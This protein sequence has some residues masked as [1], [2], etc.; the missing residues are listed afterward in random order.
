MKA[1]QH[2]LRASIIRALLLFHYSFREAARIFGVSK[3][4]VRRLYHRYCTDKTVDPRPRGGGQPPA[5]NDQ[6]LEKLRKTIAE[7]PDA[8]LSELRDLC[9]FTCSI[10]ALWRALTK[11]GWSRKKK[12]VYAC[13][14]NSPKCN[15][16]RLE[17][18]EKI[19]YIPTNRL[20]Y[21]DESGVNT[22]MTRTYAWS[23]VGERAVGLAPRNWTAYSVLS[24]LRLE[25]VVAAMVIEGSTDAAVFEAF[26]EKCLVPN[27]RPGDT[28]IWDNLSVHKSVRVKSLIENAGATLLPLPTYSPRLNPIER[29]WSKFKEFFRS[30][31]ARVAKDIYR[32]AREALDKVTSNDILGWFAD[33]MSYLPF[34]Q[35]SLA[36][37]EGKAP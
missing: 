14:A 8:T 2:D 6:Q 32:T 16:E 23:P 36:T 30:S 26:I 37:N 35:G 24:A 33:S 20:V 1:Y 22:A 5:L 4:F 9:G 7:H 10:S 28:V 18:A 3:D 15:A 31:A 13:E 11:M 29:M 12:V 19:A 27:L 25:G 34:F 21:V 17:Y